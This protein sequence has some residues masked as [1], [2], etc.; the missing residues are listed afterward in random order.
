M[1]VDN[2][3]KLTEKEYNKSLIDEHEEHKAFIADCIATRQRFSSIH[4]LDLQIIDDYVK[5]EDFAIMYDQL[6]ERLAEQY[7]IPL[8][9]EPIYDDELPF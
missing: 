3:E 1:K 2:G 4:P 5:I 7:G 9:C 8:P 6:L